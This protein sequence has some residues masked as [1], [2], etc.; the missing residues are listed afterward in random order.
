[1]IGALLSRGR[2]KGLDFAGL[3]SVGGEADLSLGELCA[4]TLDDDRI[5]SYMLFLEVIRDGPAIRRFAVGADQRGKPVVAVKIGRSSAAAEL[6]TSHTG[7]LAGEDDVA[8][9]FLADCGIARVK[10]LD[11]LLETGA[12]LRR[13]RFRRPK[14]SEPTVG[15]VTTTGG[16]AALVVDELGVRGIDVRGPDDEVLRA[17]SATGVE[18]AKGRITDL[19]LAGTNYATMT[20]ALNAMLATPNFELVI[21]VVG[22]SA[23]FQPELA[24]QPIVDVGTHHGHLVAFIVPEA[25]DALA[26][27]GGAG[28]PAFRTPEACADSVSAVLGRR[29]ARPIELPARAVGMT[30]TLDELEGYRLLSEI[31]IASAE[32]VAL[33]VGHEPG[34]ELFPAAVKILGRDLAHKSELGGVA[35]GVRTLADFG[36]VVARIRRDVS[37]RAP[38]LE[39]RRVMVQRMVTNAIGELLIGYRVDPQVGPLVLVATGGTATEVLRDRA[40][41]MAP[42]DLDTAHEMV[43]ALRSLPLLSGYRGRPAGDLEAVAR[44]LVALSNLALRSDV[45]ELEINPLVVTAEGALAVDVVARVRASSDESDGIEHVEGR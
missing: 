44:A 14:H 32:A 5:T 15:V 40:I 6:T 19:T 30:E 43:A 37:E 23:R 18:V 39:L 10:T 34:P 29:P 13:T 24:V 7:G 2:A 21:A 42:V 16:G 17:I 1:M 28:I 12:M 4:A 9:E 36:P 45:D 8:D 11:A 35:L 25:P 41:R 20:A 3:L 26:M 31:G 38:G 22:S 27:L 33:D